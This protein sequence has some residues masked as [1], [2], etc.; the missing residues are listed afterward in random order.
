[1]V[2]RLAHDLL[3]AGDDRRQLLA[4]QDKDDA[5]GA[6]LNGVPKRRPA[7]ASKRER[8]ARLLGVT[9]RD[10]GTDC[11]QDSGA[12]ETFRQKICAEGNKKAQQHL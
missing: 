4:E 12:A 3:G 11:G 9:H 5:V 1:L 8:A 10:A 2:A 7:D 6:E